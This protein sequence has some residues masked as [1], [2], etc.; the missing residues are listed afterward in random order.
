MKKTPPLENL[1]A[2]LEQPPTARYDPTTTE[3]IH[4]LQSEDFY[5]IV[6]AKIE[7][8][9]LKPHGTLAPFDALRA[10]RDSIRTKKFAKAIQIKIDA[11]SQT[12][13]TDQSITV[14]DAGCG[15]LPI[16]GMVAALRNDRVQV[17]CLEVEPKSAQAARSIIKTH[18]L[19][20]QIIVVEHDATRYVSPAPI[21]LLIS[22]TMTSAMTK[23]DCADIMGNLSKYLS[24]IGS[25]IPERVEII[26]SHLNNIEYTESPQKVTWIPKDDSRMIE[27]RVPET[28]KDVEEN[29]HQT[30]TLTL[31]TRVILHEMENII[32]EPGESIIT[33]DVVV[34]VPESES[35]QVLRYKSGYLHQATWNRK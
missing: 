15:P 34:D 30:V 32:L 10:F 18:G 24:P 27:I 29:I 25:C 4:S 19:E 17:T 5:S 26:L 7:E 16:F 28:F 2:W 1:L 33:M 22:E 20:H 14:I 3:L 6:Y 9:P 23:E 21:D 35:D 11:L 31:Q 8:D 13:P 12:I